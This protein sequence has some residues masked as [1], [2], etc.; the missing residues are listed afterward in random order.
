MLWR[1]EKSLSLVRNWI[2][3]IQPIAQ[4]YTDL[5]IPAPDLLVKGGMILKWILMK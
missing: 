3:G 2:P 1:S 5:A 4:C